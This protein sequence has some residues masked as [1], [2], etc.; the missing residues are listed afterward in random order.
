MKSQNS[1]RKLLYGLCILAVMLCGG[2]STKEER[3]AKHQA[4]IEAKALAEQEAQTKKAAEEAER[5]R[6]AA[7]P[8]TVIGTDTYTGQKYYDKKIHHYGGIDEW[9]RYSVYQGIIYFDTDGN[10][11]TLE[12]VAVKSLPCADSRAR[13]R[14]IHPGDSKTRAE[15]EAALK[16]KDEKGCSSEIGVRT[17]HSLTW[18][19]VN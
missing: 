1:T 10:T 9:R 6:I 4:A 19:R 7:I 3:A 18:D 16:H 15:W 2:C 5:Q 12:Y 11:N 8:Y 17:A 13:F 14:L